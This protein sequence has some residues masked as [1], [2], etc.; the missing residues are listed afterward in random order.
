MYSARCALDSSSWFAWRI[1]LFWLQQSSAVT[2]TSVRDSLLEKFR[3]YRLDVL[4]T[5]F[6][7]VAED[8]RI[9]DSAALKTKTKFFSVNVDDGPAD[10]QAQ[11]VEIQLAQEQVCVI[12]R[13]RWVYA[14]ACLA[15]ADRRVVSAVVLA[16]CPT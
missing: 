15:F 1:T 8:A 12:P 6:D 11:L 4:F 7:E 14:H 2:C 13:W 16:G 10:T 3:R 9:R 5:E